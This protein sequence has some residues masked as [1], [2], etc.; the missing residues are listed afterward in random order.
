V[1]GP[2][3]VADTITTLPLATAPTGAPEALMA[4]ASAVARLESVVEPE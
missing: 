3:D 2:V 4:E 1:L